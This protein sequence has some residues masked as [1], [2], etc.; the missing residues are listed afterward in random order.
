[1]GKI[2]EE[3][4]S[5]KVRKVAWMRNLS[6]RAAIWPGP[7][8]LFVQVYFPLDGLISSKSH[9]RMMSSTHSLAGSLTGDPPFFFR[10]Q[11]YIEVIYQDDILGIV[12]GKE[13]LY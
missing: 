7:N 12:Q 11:G 13:G 3:A 2:F 10:C 5:P 6:R 1:M 9:S 4:M 8:L